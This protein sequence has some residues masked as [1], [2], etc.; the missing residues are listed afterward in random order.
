MKTLV[1]VDVQQDFLPGGA[2]GV[3]DSD[4]IIPLINDFLPCFERVVAT[5]DWHP[6][7]HASFA[8]THKKA[9]G[10][11]IQLQGS[12]Q[13]LWP[14]HCVQSKPGSNF[15]LRLELARIEAIF[16]KGTDP[17]VDSYSAFF[18]HSRRRSTGLEAY[19][20]SQ[21]L[22]NLYFVGLATDYC[23]LY[24]VLDALELGFDVTVIRDAC[25]AI[26]L[27]SGD[28]ER[29]LLVMEEKGANIISSHAVMTGLW[30]KSTRFT[31]K[32]SSK[33]VGI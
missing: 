23:V 26:N 15:A 9:V 30:T 17:K 22:T 6:E 19:L 16:Q 4:K 8:S 11:L 1:I 21:Q 12:S 7:R 24:S 20:R 3:P 33:E 13:I 27:D 18:D 14:D 29:A 31:H 28:E 10:D 5:M 32:I 25:R 2:L